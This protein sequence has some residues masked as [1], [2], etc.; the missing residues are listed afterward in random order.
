MRR[1]TPAVLAYLASRA[2]FGLF[3]V[4]RYDPMGEPLHIGKLALDL[5]VFIA[6]YYGFSWLLGRLRPVPSTDER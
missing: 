5:G 4:Q 6:F 2:V 3:D 1:L